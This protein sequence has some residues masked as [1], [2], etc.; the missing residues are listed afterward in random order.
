[1]GWSAFLAGQGLFTD[2]GLDPQWITALVFVLLAT[3]PAA[4]VIVGRNRSALIAA[5]VISVPLSVMSLA[6]ATLPLLIPA[7]LYGA[8]AYVA[9]DDR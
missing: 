2:G 3:A 4:I 5:A 6:G 1:L 8:A 9:R 7:I